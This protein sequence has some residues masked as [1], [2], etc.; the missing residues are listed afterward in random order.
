MN[1]DEV[2]T[3]L[4]EEYPRH[5]DAD[6]QPPPPLLPEQVE[7]VRELLA[8]AVRQERAEHSIEF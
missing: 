5:R 1:P 6:G 3:M 4:L 2:A 8:R 7:V